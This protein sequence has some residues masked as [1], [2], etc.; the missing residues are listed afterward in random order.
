MSDP[1]KNIGEFTDKKCAY[2]EELLQ[3]T[4]S[5]I[6][7]TKEVELIST[8]AYNQGVSSCETCF[9]KLAEVRRV[10]R[11][12]GEKNESA[13]LAKL[14]TLNNET[15]SLLMNYGTPFLRDVLTIVFGTAYFGWLNSVLAESDKERFDCILKYFHPIGFKSILSKVSKESGGVGGGVSVTSIGKAS[16]SA[17][18]HGN[19]V[20]AIKPSISANSS[21]KKRDGDKDRDG[22]A[23][24]SAGT[25]TKRR[26]KEAPIIISA[27]VE[28]LGEGRPL[29]C[30]EL[31]SDTLPLIANI[32]G[33][34]ILFPSADGDKTIIMNGIF[35]RVSIEHSTDAFIQNQYHQFG[36][37][38]HKRWGG[39][40]TEVASATSPPAVTTGTTEVGG[41]NMV[42]SG[43]GTGPTS[44][45]SNVDVS[46]GEVSAGG[47]AVAGA[48][49]TP[50]LT[51]DIPTQTLIESLPADVRWFLRAIE[52]P[53][54]FLH[55]PESYNTLFK[56]RSNDAEM[57]HKKP[58]QTVVR[59]FLRAPLSSQRETLM[60][61]L[62]QSSMIEYQ[63]L[64][65]LLYDLLSNEPAGNGGGGGS[66]GGGGGMGVGGGSGS[67]AGGGAGFGSGIGGGGSGS[68]SRMDSDSQVKLYDSLP[69]VYRKRFR[70]AMRATIMYTRQLAEF[71]QQKIPLEQQ[72]CLMKT[73]DS[74]KEKAM[75]KLRE[76]KS[77]SEDS[78]S[79]ARQ[80][81]EGLLRIPFGVIRREPVFTI[82]ERTRQIYEKQREVISEI[83]TDALRGAALSVYPETTKI[84]D[85]TSVILSPMRCPTLAEVRTFIRDCR[86][87][88]LSAVDAHNLGIVVRVLTEGKRRPELIGLIKQMNGFLKK[89]E[90]EMTE[91][92]GNQKAI[93]KRYRELG[94]LKKV[95]QSG[96]KTEVLIEEI[97]RKLREIYNAGVG[98]EAGGRDGS[99]T[100][101][102]VGDELWGCVITEFL[103]G[104]SGG[105]T[106]AG[107]GN[108]LISR[109]IIERIRAEIAPIERAIQPINGEMERIRRVL[110]D[111]VYG[112]KNAKRQVER[113]MAQ[114]MNGEQ[115]GY[116]FGFEGPPGVGKTSLAKKGL[117]DCIIDEHGVTR[118]FGFIAIGGSSNG[119]TL[120]GHNYTYVGSV[121]G[122]IVDILM[123]SKCMNPI[124][125]IDE[126]DKV[127]TTEHGKEIIGILTHL[128]DTT[129]NNTFQD[130]YFNGIDIDLSK[131][132]FVFSYNDPDK[133]D[134]ILLDR[135][136]RIK[137]DPLTLKDKLVI[138]RKYILPE[139]MKRAGL[140]EQVQIPDETV[141]YI[142]N[143]Y[144]Y[145]SGVRKLKE[146]LTEIIGEINLEFL[147]H[148]RRTKIVVTPAMIKRHYLKDHHPIMI[149][150]IMPTP[151]V[152]HI[153]GLWANA[154]GKGGILPIE[155]KFAV[156]DSFL[157]MELTGQQG[158]VMKESMSVARNLA[159]RLCG[160]KC[161]AEMSKRC[162]EKHSLKGI[163]IHCP[164][165]ATPK[166]GPS[167]G[168]A[169]TT[170][171]Y[172]LFTG[173]P[174]PN[175][176]AMTGEIDLHGNI[177]IIGGLEYK[178]L[179]GI[180]GGVKRFFYPRENERDFQR[181]KKVYIDGEDDD[182]G[183]IDETELE[184][185]TE[186]LET[187]SE[188]GDDDEEEDVEIELDLTKSAVGVVAG[189]GDE[190][191]SDGI[192]ATVVEKPPKRP[193]AS[194]GIL[195]EVAKDITFT[196]VSSIKEVIFALF[197]DVVT[198]N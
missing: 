110:S 64:T 175:D 185:E 198:T 136:H 26:A 8:N 157:G 27:G 179:G 135:I 127:S 56:Q 148:E 29:T 164:E 107:D 153:C 92:G 101:A 147:T 66:G 197:G 155:L 176:V 34:R 120:E 129:Q 124:I 134:R 9:S 32:R 19:S 44:E 30:I 6:H 11:E 75:I 99:D 119:S 37:E 69:W 186:S 55:T 121:W 65:Y 112:H 165:G 116:C 74:I 87:K 151:A 81:L 72:I 31:A 146:L 170:A 70:E 130:K 143:R 168:A 150:T 25:S 140:I 196:P 191:E 23:D 115:T 24:N 93:L 160:E 20:I 138:V 174:I 180:H 95:P 12:G 167:A 15:C 68:G 71:D 97:T 43:S 141:Q 13:L 84:R 192:I 59:D 159:Y 171:M 113:I 117:A 181:F 47:C 188:V 100:L 45:I 178:L 86:E 122:R 152:G 79:K 7:W 39:A 111:A 89:R 41:I 77:K 169:I 109:P 21:P 52:L 14:Q 17:S 102:S 184:T 80:Y 166:D 96:L 1:M 193:T 53:D 51:V 94:I 149:E 161:R 60:V 76:I 190:G 3:R 163:H 40:I 91:A 133:L 67:G 63:Y 144:T 104:V 61:L 78:G 49:A 183:V 139:I 142:I 28:T 90:T 103:G 82:V 38:F 182:Y 158:D 172:S 4:I 10:R 33:M 16:T 36:L 132:L 162:E 106:E 123:E 98:A 46:G 173:K 145:E 131:V 83:L 88:I 85:A 18:T 35:E 156:G 62:S 195:A 194:G 58:I 5:W 54:L 2:F 108:G 126:L 137:F 114:W 189:A 177:T 57:L 50:H 118:P 187:E 48:G 42:I 128:V 125:F 73:S 105:G 22:D 154:Y